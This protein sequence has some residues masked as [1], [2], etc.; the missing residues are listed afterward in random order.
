MSTALFIGHVKIG[1]MLMYSGAI[2]VLAKRHRRLYVVCEYA[3]EEDVKQLLCTTLPSVHVVPVK[4]NNFD[5]IQAALLPYV[6]KWQHIYSSGEWKHGYDLVRKVPGFTFPGSLYDDIAMPRHVR[7]EKFLVPPRSTNV[8]P[9]EQDYIF[10]ADRSSDLSLPLYEAL[11]WLH[12]GTLVVSADRND[13]YDKGSMFHSLCEK[14][15]RTSD[16]RITDYIDLIRGASEIHCIDSALWCI[17]DTLDPS[18]AAKKSVFIRYSFVESRPSF[19]R[20]N[21]NDAV[22]LEAA[23]RVLSR[24]QLRRPI[25]LISFK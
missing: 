21:C 6:S 13:V 3:C 17:S 23:I 15:V 24:R 5:S 4:Y 9:P 19:S 20:Y 1:D 25:N 11:V 12:P 14:L 16:T 10:V 7:F 18:K 22:T 8:D 2:S